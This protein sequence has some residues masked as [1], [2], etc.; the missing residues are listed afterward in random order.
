MINECGRKQET[1]FSVPHYLTPIERLGLR[2]FASGVAE[3]GITRDHFAA[4]LSYPG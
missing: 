3:R 2:T 4:G 1:A